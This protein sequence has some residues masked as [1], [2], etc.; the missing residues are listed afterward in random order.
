MKNNIYLV[1]FS[2]LITISL[3][4]LFLLL[5]TYLSLNKNLTYKFNSVE[6]LNFHKK[7]SNKIHHLRGG[8]KLFK[9]N[10]PSSNFLYSIINNFK[11]N[12]KNILFQGDS[13][14]AQLNNEDREKFYL[15]QNLV[16]N[17]SLEKDLGF[18][19][20]GISSF[21]PTLMMLQLEVL[22][23]DF[24]INPNI[25][26]AY[27]D[28][29]DIGDENCRY[30]NN[31]VYK[32][33]KLIAV[34]EEKFS[35]LPFDYSKVYGE[36][37]ILLTKKSQFIKSFYLTNF[38]IY[39]AV[40]KSINKNS[41]KIN[42]LL[43]SDYTKTSL[44]HWSEIQKYLTNSTKS[45]LTYF[46]ESILSYVNYAINVKDLN[47][48]LLVTFPHKNNLENAGSANKYKYNVSNIIDNLNISNEK[49]V[50]LNFSK[51]ISE[52]KIL[53]NKDVYVLNDPGSHLTD[54]FYADVFIR[55]ILNRV[56]DF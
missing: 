32:N 31:K 3:L 45:E 55:E 35:N 33:N 13:W 9:K 36:S 40:K 24:N 49:V 38:K 50:H 28:Q 43:N 48:L 39:Y 53:L 5:N 15:A 47:K 17:F 4:Y 26:I 23:K 27:I 10:M 29:S 52:K 2:T 18:I 1:F 12:R 51:L 14:V 56:I 37:A 34:K 41:K 16:K 46:K 8:K 44:C 20:A 7:Y 42:Q 25:I 30:K 21:S 19:N 6:N 11:N 22:I 54:E